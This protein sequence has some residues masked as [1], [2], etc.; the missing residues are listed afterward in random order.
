MAKIEASSSRTLDYDLEEKKIL[1]GLIDAFSSS[2]TLREICSAFCKAGRNPD[3]AAEILYDCEGNNSDAPVPI[4][5]ER[6][7]RSTSSSEP[8][9]ES[10]AINSKGSKS[11]PITSESETRRTSQSEPSCE[12]VANRSGCA[13][14]NSKGSKP[15]KLSVS[16]GTVSS[17]LG[18]G[19]AATNTSANVPVRAT[20]P[21][22]VD[23][24]DFLVDELIDRDVSSD[25]AAMKD[26]MHTGIEEFV[27]K[28][29]GNDGFQLDMDVIRE[30]LGACG[31][32]AEKSMERLTDLS[33][34]KMKNDKDIIGSST[35]KSCPQ[36]AESSK[37]KSSSSESSEQMDLR[38]SRD[39]ERYDLQKE[40]L[41][42]LFN[43]PEMIDEDPKRVSIGRR[44]VQ[45]RPGRKIVTEPYKDT[46]H[47]TDFLKPLQESDDEKDDRHKVLRRVATEHWT[48]M[49]EYFKSAFDAYAKG[50]LAL[51]E[52]LR[53]EG[54]SYNKKAR[55]ADEMSNQLNLVQREEKESYVTPVDLRDFD[56]GEAISK[57]KFYLKTHS[58]IPGHHL[59]V[60]IDDG[61]TKK[62]SRRRRVLKLLEKES[63]KW[64]G[65]GNEGTI[66]IQMDEIN[67]TELSFYGEK[68]ASDDDE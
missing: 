61:D 47:S 37:L 24:K 52:Q 43:V 60:V 41:A 30:V 57:M 26:Q 7:K 9:P 38:Q 5:F 48:T 31:Y 33:A 46:E 8:L 15:K 23:I 34:L 40:V 63:I 39:K 10:I 16:I 55:D 3:M 62:A 56:K 68:N 32:D 20:K 28:M 11:I 65:E 14:R 13:D 29:L 18:K 22:K 51:A 21:L 50:N 12:S 45:P 64:T 67:P 6:E 66:W 36:I 19:Y 54:Q 4:T 58:G 35:P 49:K 1:Q 27:F 42:S 53:E 25:S 2:F 59:K 17:V 44:V